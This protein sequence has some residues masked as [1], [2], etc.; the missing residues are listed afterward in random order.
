[1]RRVVK[2]PPI[3]HLLFP[4]SVLPPALPRV[5]PQGLPSAGCPASARW[6]VFSF[7]HIPTFNPG[8]RSLRMAL[9]R[10]LGVSSCCQMRMTVQQWA[11]RSRFCDRSRFLLPSILASHHARR[12]AGIFARVGCPCQKSPST[13]TAIFSC[14]NT[15][16]GRTKHQELR[17]KNRCPIRHQASDFRILAFQFFSI[18]PSLLPM[19]NWTRDQL[20]AALN[21]YHRTLFG[22]QH[23]TCPPI[24]ELA[25]QMGR[26]PSA[27]AMELNSS[28]SEIQLAQ[29]ALSL[30]IQT[31]REIPALHPRRSQR[32][33]PAG[34][35]SAGRCCHHCG[36]L[37]RIARSGAGLRVGG[38]QCLG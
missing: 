18:F 5:S 8:A 16:S 12:V 36:I 21:L 28:T 31:N 13:K 34:E 19:P 23:K 20:L 22:R 14:R 10:C 3:S 4:V 7:P 15:K 2:W 1:M 17:T 29:P 33:F 35:S 6:H 38:I 11:R 32:R 24:V 37:R 27:V 26:T 25:A 30:Y 9:A